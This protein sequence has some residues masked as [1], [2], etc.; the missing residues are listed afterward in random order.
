MTVLNGSEVQWLSGSVARWFGGSPSG[1]VGE[2]LSS[3]PLLRLP[4]R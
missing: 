1:P 4:R 3:T 2:S